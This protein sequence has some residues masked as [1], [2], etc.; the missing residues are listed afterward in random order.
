MYVRCLPELWGPIRKHDFWLKTRGIPTTCK[1]VGAVMSSRVLRRWR[2]GEG[3]PIS[4]NEGSGTGKCLVGVSSVKWAL[5][6]F[7]V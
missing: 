6:V 3:K 1:L 5:L 2:T 4:E 7:G